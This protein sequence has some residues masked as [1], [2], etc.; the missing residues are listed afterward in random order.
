MMGVAVRPVLLG[1]RRPACRGFERGDTRLKSIEIG[2]RYA[3]TP[4]RSHRVTH[5]AHPELRRRRTVTEFDGYLA[6]LQAAGLGRKNTHPVSRHEGDGFGIG[7]S[8]SGI[9]RGFGVR[10][11]L[12]VVWP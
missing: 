2:L 8:G 4:G 6:G 1:R 12:I 7:R 10:T 3:T 11:G 9:G 5:A